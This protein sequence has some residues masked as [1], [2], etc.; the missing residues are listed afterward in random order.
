MI[1]DI[2]SIVIGQRII[3]TLSNTVGKNLKMFLTIF[4]VNKEVY[5]FKIY[6]HVFVVSC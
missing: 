2:R 4:V 5:S 3:Y 1:L 6:C